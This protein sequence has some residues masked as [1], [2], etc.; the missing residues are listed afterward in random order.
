MEGN[1]TKA[2]DRGE[3]CEKEAD[4]ANNVM[5]KGSTITIVE[6]TLE[7]KV[8]LIKIDVQERKKGRGFMQRI[9]EVSDERYSGKPMTAQCLRDNA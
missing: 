1:R 5:Q 6:W 9:K 3:N 4:E 2:E 8:S 7:M